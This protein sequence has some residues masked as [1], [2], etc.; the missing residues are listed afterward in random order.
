MSRAESC[1]IRV[2]THGGDFS[3]IPLPSSVSAIPAVFPSASESLLTQAVYLSGLFETPPLCSGLGRCGRCR[4]RFLP[5]SSCIP[6]ATGQDLQVLGREAVELGWRLG[7][8]HQAA[9]GM[10][11]ELPE[12]IQPLHAGPGALCS[13]GLVELAEL[14]EMTGQ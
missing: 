6:E 1:F 9:P 2:F 3:D 7:C 12:N 5:Q 8:R 13:A 4:M 11:I 10:V 14:P